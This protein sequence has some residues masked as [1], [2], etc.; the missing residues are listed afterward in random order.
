V[1]VLQRLGYSWGNTAGKIAVAIGKTLPI[2][3]GVQPDLC[4]YIRWVHSHRLGSTRGKRLSPGAA[5][6]FYIPVLEGARARI[7]QSE[8]GEI[9]AVSGPGHAPPRPPASLRPSHI[10]SKR[11]YRPKLSVVTERKSGPRSFTQRPKRE[12]DSRHASAQTENRHSTRGR[13]FFTLVFPPFPSHSCSAN[14]I[15]TSFADGA[16]GRIAADI[17]HPPTALRLTSGQGRSW[18]RPRFGSF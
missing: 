18:Y 11:C 5:S 14:A 12:R 13:S 17:A 10:I 15:S 1:P 7:R 6:L 16:I 2:L 9:S 3:T 8:V 4:S